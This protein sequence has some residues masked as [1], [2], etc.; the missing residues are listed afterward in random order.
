MNF[1]FSFG[2]IDNTQHAQDGQLMKRKGKNKCNNS[3]NKKKNTKRRYDLVFLVCQCFITVALL[4]HFH[5]KHGRRFIFNVIHKFWVLLNYGKVCEFFR[6]STRLFSIRFLFFYVCLR[7]FG[8]FEHD[9]SAGGRMASRK[10][11]FHPLQH[12]SLI[13]F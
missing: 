2:W 8:T 4:F 6:S 7:C 1:H 13:F 9:V 11:F 10:N 12:I 3:N 5:Y